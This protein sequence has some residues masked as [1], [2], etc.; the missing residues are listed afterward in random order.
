MTYT[1]KTPFAKRQEG[2]DRRTARRNAI[3]AKQSFLNTGHVA[4]ELVK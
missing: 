1:N 3:M 2:R 4:G